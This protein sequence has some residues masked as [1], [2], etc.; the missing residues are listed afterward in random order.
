MSKL[1]N[2]FGSGGMSLALNE[3]QFSQ[4]VQHLKNVNPSFPIRTAVCMIG[5]QE[6][7]SVW[8]MGA[9]LQVSESGENIPEMERTIVWHSTSIEESIG[10][11]D[12]LPPLLIL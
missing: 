6:G 9:D 4:F 5:K 12:P 3:A 8:V 10:K 11:A 2:S 7:C 1:N